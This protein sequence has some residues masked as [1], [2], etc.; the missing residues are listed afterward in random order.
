MGFFSLEANQAR[1]QNEA[2]DRQI[3]IAEREQ[4][5]K[6][7]PFNT[8]LQS[9]AQAAP[10]AAAQAMGNMAVNE[11][12]YEYQGG[13][14]A[15]E[16]GE[17][18]N[19]A[20]ETE[21]NRSALATEASN[22]RLRDM[23]QRAQLSAE[24]AQQPFGRAELAREL[25]PETNQGVQPQGIPHQAQQGTTQ[26][27]M[28]AA[29]PRPQKPQKVSEKYS[30]SEHLSKVP[31]VDEVQRGDGPLP[32]AIK[33]KDGSV[34]ATDEELAMAMENASPELRASL[35]MLG[36]TGLKP[37]Y[38]MIKGEKYKKTTRAEAKLIES[39]RNEYSDVDQTAATS[40]KL[41]A[42]MAEREFPGEGLGSP[43]VAED[44]PEV[45]QR[46]APVDRGAG[47]FMW[48]PEGPGVGGR[49][50]PQREAEQ[51]YGV[52]TGYDGGVG[53]ARHGDAKFRTSAENV[54]LNKSEIAVYDRWSKDFEKNAARMISYAAAPTGSD[55]FKRFA[56]T[57]AQSVHTLPDSQKPRAISAVLQ[58]LGSLPNDK[59]AAAWKAFAKEG[60]IGLV[61]RSKGRSTNI[62]VTPGVKI[63]DTQRSHTGSILQY[64]KE[65]EVR[66][67]EL[68]D[69]VEN[70]DGEEYQKSLQNNI[71]YFKERIAYHHSEYKKLAKKQNVTEFAA[72]REYWV[73]GKSVM[74][75]TLNTGEL[76][77][78]AGEQFATQSKVEDLALE[79]R[80]SGKKKRAY[81]K[82]IKD[83]DLANRAEVV[84]KLK[85]LDHDIGA[86][87]EYLAEVVV[88]NDLK[89]GGEKRGR[90]LSKKNR[91][92][93][94]SL[95]GDF[96]VNAMTA[97]GMEGQPVD[98]GLIAD[99]I[100]INKAELNSY[101]KN[102]VAKNTTS[103]AKIL[104]YANQHPD[105]FGVEQAK[106]QDVTPG[107]YDD[108]A[109]MNT[110]L[111]LGDAGT[112][113]FSGLSVPQQ[114]YLLSNKVS[115]AQLEAMTSLKTDVGK[116]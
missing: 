16:E 75:S 36:N 99:A 96:K 106:T 32:G 4:R 107:G 56:E 21:T 116:L 45:R 91:A 88:S 85:E 62:K 87:T 69:A 92:I 17:R 39:M 76:K 105:V 49:Q 115:K 68:K 101:L 26:G 13:R 11:V 27:L 111:K 51:A 79:I 25:Y 43:G 44:L 80:T 81:V 109:K 33:M 8:L 82:A 94:K 3:S 108:A 98:T 35:E 71:D 2:R 100:G 20:T 14:R 12:K 103:A 41:M 77:K 47:G 19:L 53:S 65:L 66:K 114:T 57:M 97:E 73:N 95:R 54:A 1:E 31:S 112:A 9:F 42:K 59:Q 37:E 10:Q 64:N 61:S 6:Q 38:V 28:D 34:L 78:H 72:E 102:G 46:Q 74:L 7:N 52:P 23:Q 40:P 84:A 93:M 50:S 113:Y 29:I 86:Y 22:N 18:R 67:K 104:E 110:W 30:P 15:L 48:N 90:D 63:A 70:G 89:I 83:S 55:S 58:K 60:R 24:Y 5:Y